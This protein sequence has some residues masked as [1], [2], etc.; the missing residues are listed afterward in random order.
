MGRSKGFRK[1][2]D[3]TTFLEDDRA[4]D[5]PEDWEPE[6]RPDVLR[7]ELDERLLLPL[8]VAELR[9]GTLSCAV[10]LKP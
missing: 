8:F 7:E 1:R 2:A 3:L 4:S 6:D 10:P 9:D 5:E